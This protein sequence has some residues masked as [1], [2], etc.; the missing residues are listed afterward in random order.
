MPIIKF[1]LIALLVNIN[2][3]NQHQISSSIMVFGNVTGLALEWLPFSNIQTG[4]TKSLKPKI[5]WISFYALVIFIQKVPVIL[6]H[7]IHINYI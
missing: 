7:N 6:G 2:I 1:V 4:F 3:D 5:Q